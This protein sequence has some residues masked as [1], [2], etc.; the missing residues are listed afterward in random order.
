MRFNG[1]MTDYQRQERHLAQIAEAV[2]AG[3]D[4]S[5]PVLNALQHGASWQTIAEHCGLTPRAAYD[6]WGTYSAANAGYDA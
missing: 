4:P 6:R 1:R 2:S 5:G 3:S